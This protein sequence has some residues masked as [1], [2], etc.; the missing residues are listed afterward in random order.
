MNKRKREIEGTNQLQLKLPRRILPEYANPLASVH[1]S[2]HL[3]LLRLPLYINTFTWH[4][5][6]MYLGYLRMLPL[7]CTHA[8]I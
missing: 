5:S 7:Y 8:S 2:L 1:S 6:F 3:T 4:V